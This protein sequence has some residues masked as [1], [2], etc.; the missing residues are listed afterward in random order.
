MK[1]LFL[2]V[3]FLIAFK[4]GMAMAANEYSDPDGAY[5]IVPPPEWKI[6]PKG[7]NEV[8]FRARI[9]DQN[10]RPGIWIVMVPSHGVQPIG[11]KEEAEIKSLVAEGR[12]EFRLVT[13]E[14]RSFPFGEAYLVS[15]EHTFQNLRMKTAEA[16]IVHRGTKYLVNFNTLTATFDKYF[17]VYLKSLETFSPAEQE[18]YAF[19]PFA[20]RLQIPTG[21]VNVKATTAER[22]GTIGRGEAI[23]AYAVA[24]VQLTRRRA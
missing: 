5:S 6:I 18:D 19:V 14:R 16:H 15:Y 21:Q 9:A 10:Y 3:A 4:P 22:V 24:A 12:D 17:P 23:A 11:P 20:K 13:S 1:T 2:T 8:E 7:R